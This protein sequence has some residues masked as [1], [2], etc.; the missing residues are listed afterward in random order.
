MNCTKLK[1]VK[2][3]GFVWKMDQKMKV[4]YSYQKMLNYITKRK[5]Y[6]NCMVGMVLVSDDL[7]K[8]K[9]ILDRLP[10]EDSQILKDEGNSITIMGIDEKNISLQLKIGRAKV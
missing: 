10:L 7:L 9:V 3:I 2:S 4:F 6:K 8:D 1:M 5:D